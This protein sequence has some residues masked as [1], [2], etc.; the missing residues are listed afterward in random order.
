MKLEGNFCRTRAG[1]SIAT[2]VIDVSTGSF[3]AA[4][5]RI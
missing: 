2:C 4:P 1:V 5:P 3:F